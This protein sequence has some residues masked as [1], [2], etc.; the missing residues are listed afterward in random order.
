MT[1]QEPQ[2]VRAHMRMRVREGCEEAFERAWRA[3]AEAI[4]R[5]P[6][7]VGQ[8]MLRETGDGRD[9]CIVSEWTD[10]R[11]LREFGRSTLRDRLTAELRDLRD[12]CEQEAYETMHTVEGRGPRIRVVVSTTVPEDETE[13]FEQAYLEVAAGMRGTPGH[14]REE[15]LREPGTARYHLFAE[16][17]DDASFQAWVGDPRHTETTA[18]IVP[19]LIRNMDRKTYLVAA[20]LGEIPHVPRPPEVAADVDVL[21]VGAGPT[22]LTTAIELARRGVSCR[23][24]DKAPHAAT[25][26][27]KA[28][29]VHCRT[30]E[31]WEDM[32]VVRAAMDAGI[33][34]KGE[35]VYVNGDRVIERSWELPDLPYAHLGLPQYET[36]RIL[37][38]R[39]A[40]LGVR[41]EYGNELLEFVQDDDTVT[42]RL[43]LADGTLT[44]VR[45]RYL[46]GSDGAHSIVRRQLGLQF[47]GGLG[48]FPEL[49]ML[50][51]VEVDWDLPGNELIR[52]VQMTEGKITDMLVAVP[53]RGD[54]RYRLATTAP[55]RYWAETG[56]RKAPPGFTAELAQPTI[57]DFQ[58][59]VEQLAPPGTQASNLRWSSVFR[60][61]HGI[62]DRYRDGRVFVAGDAAHLHPPAGGQG[63]NTGIQDAYNLGWK[64]ALAAKGLGSPQLLDSYEAERLPAGAD[65]VNRSVNFDFTAQRDRKED[66]LEFLTEMQLLLRYDDSPIIGESVDGDTARHGGP[67]AGGRAPD[68]G[69]LTRPGVCRLLQLGDL[70]RGTAHTLLLYA[71]RTATEED[72]LAT[73]KIAAEARELAHGQLDVYLVA[74][75]DTRLAMTPDPPVIWDEAGEFR[76]VYHVSGTAAYLVRP[77]GHVGFRSQP[78]DAEALRRHLAGTF[79]PT[80]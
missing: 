38:A 73:E 64:L 43:K 17:E 36:E 59:A 67:P 70:T 51:D 31:I 77:D 15:L 7:N 65:V 23:V 52:F 56:G 2:R 66:E 57:A 46:V 79:A 28:I 40:E 80:R 61:S 47:E 78:F 1:E 45:S 58:Q 62:V 63:M 11:S 4:S 48:R 53:L 37:G 55:Q 14:V 74:G 19:Y 50:G 20:E 16:W 42:A 41:V 49:Y 22:G 3:T 76:C 54:G 10:L 72:L 32:G 27:D 44:T 68:V 24:V 25:Q 39:L 26:A 5:V 60:I 30:M 13:V 75:P 69:G 34:F 6:G 18:P 29:G 21:V 35:A 9:V 33:W 8:K 12:S 71:D